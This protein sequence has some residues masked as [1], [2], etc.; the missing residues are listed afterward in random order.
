MRLTLLSTSI[1]LSVA[2]M[3][4]AHSQT[5]ITLYSGD[6]DAVSQSYPGAQMPGLA[7]V[8]QALVRELAKGE[9]AVSLDLLPTAID[10]G[11]VQ[12]APVNTGPRIAGQRY[13]F[14]LLDQNQLLNQSLGQRV[15]VEQATGGEVRR[16]TGVLISAGNG[17]TLK[18]DDGRVR[19]LANYD[20]FELERAPEGL[21]ARPTLRWTI[22][23][24]RAGKENFQLDYATGGLAWQAEYLARLDGPAQDCR[25]ALSG[26]AQIVNRSGLDF[27]AA[28]L[29]LVAG[30]PNQARPAAPDRIQVSGTVMSMAKRADAYEAAPQVQDSGEYHAYPLRSAVDLPNGSVQRA[31]L[32]D[33]A[34]GIDCLRRYE[35]GHAGG[36]YRPSYPQVHTPSGEQAEQARTVL[37]FENAAGLGLGMPLPAGR[38]RVFQTDA[39]GESL[40]GEARLAHTAS[41]Q[42]VRLELGEA[43]DLTARRKASD[44]RL[45]DDRLSLVET[46]EVTLSNAKLQ[47]ATVRVH[48]ALGRWQDWEILDASQPWEKVDAQSIVFDLKV[49]ASKSATARY[50]VRYRWPAAV[51]P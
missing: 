5:R 48:E 29:T 35:V 24:P 20:S 33:A 22:D 25:M 31:S 32:I 39:R 36:G 10:V 11:T 9:N 17:L 47:D 14:A 42:K 2:A 6:F 7:L 44:F 18:Q 16:F 1:L 34:E 43:F 46:I 4:P 49:A 40:L 45:A 19:V 3:N 30:N 21:S 51:K 28:A 15:T 50:T 13:D 27:P 38:V 37:E 26:A 12:L 8:E 41:G 23:S